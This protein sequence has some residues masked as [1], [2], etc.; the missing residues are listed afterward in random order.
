LLDWTENVMIAL[1]FPVE[2]NPGAH[3]AAVWALDPTRLNRKLRR[4]I[5]GAMLPD[6]AEAESY[7]PDLEAGFAGQSGTVIE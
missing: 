3:Y 2:G 5:V 4:G 7:L 6:W 1:Y